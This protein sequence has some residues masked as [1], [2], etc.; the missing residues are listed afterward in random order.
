M[1][2]PWGRRLQARIG[3][4]DGLKLL[5]DATTA[6]LEYAMEQRKRLIGRSYIDT[7][8]MQKY[9]DA[10]REQGVSTVGELAEY[11]EEN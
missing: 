7:H 8:P 1:T 4:R 10:M 9:I 11:Q 2:T 3:T 6:D 5:R